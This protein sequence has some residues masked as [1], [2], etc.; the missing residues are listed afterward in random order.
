[1]NNCECVK[2]IKISSIVQNSTGVVLIPSKTLYPLDNC[3]NVEM[4]ICTSIPSITTILPVFISTSIGNLPVLCRIG[5]SF[6]IDQLNSRRC[7]HMAFG[8]N[9]NHFLIK[10]CVCPS[11]RFVT[12][13]SSTESQTV[14]I[15]SKSAKINE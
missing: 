14:T 3:Q 6:M 1:M 2:R 7:Y 13:T 11:K 4:I 15:N 5:N 10:D 12:T 9:P 8:N